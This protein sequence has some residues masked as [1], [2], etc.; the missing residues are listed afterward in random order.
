MLCSCHTEIFNKCL[1]NSLKYLCLTRYC[2]SAG[3]DF[4]NDFYRS[5]TRKSLYDLGIHLLYKPE[6]T[7]EEIKITNMQHPYLLTIIHNL[8]IGY[9][10]YPKKLKNPMLS[11]S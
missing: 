3:T 8:L 5:S 10:Y 9:L 6:N 1:Q 7:G 2:S 4:E 11:S